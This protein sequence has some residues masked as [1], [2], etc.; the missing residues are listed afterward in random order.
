M[1]PLSIAASTAGLLTLTAQIISRGYACIARLKSND[2]DVRTA[3]N[4]V[5]SFSGILTA[6]ESQCKESAAPL[7]SPLHHLIVN[8]QPSWKTKVEECE[9]VLVDMTG[10][11]DALAKANTAQLLVKG[12]S[13]NTKLEKLTMQI[14]KSKS[15]FILC[16]QLQNNVDTRSSQKLSSKI[17]SSLDLLRDEQDRVRRETELKERKEQQQ[18]S[19]VIE[20]IQTQ[21]LD[22]DSVILYHF[23]RFS[24]EVA[25]SQDRLVGA[26]I[27]QLLD[28]LPEDSP[29]PDALKTMLKRSRFSS[30]PR[31][32]KLKDIF[33]ELCMSHPTIYL[34]VD[35]VDE[36]S[37]SKEFIKFLRNLPT[38]GITIKVFIASR[39]KTE[40]N[41]AFRGYNAVEI[42]PEDVESDMQ[43][44]VRDRLEELL[45]GDEEEIDPGLLVMELA[46]RA[47]GM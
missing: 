45:S 38:M 21:C 23:C 47:D 32:A 25:R 16:L 17:M 27:T 20:F 37:D 7:S 3:V 14:E 24:D 43:M 33:Q 12:S 30:Y 6:V 18:G 15:F 22:E 39:Q 19:R 26:L 10:I 29:L 35:G 44:F 4:E 1:D 40:L 13:L 2:E 11:L 31:I 42:T 34:V 8:N 41:T 9:A 28:Q 5:A 46:S 36:L